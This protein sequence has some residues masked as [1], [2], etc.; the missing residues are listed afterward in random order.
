MESIVIKTFLH[1]FPHQPS[2]VAFD[3]IQRLLAIGT[4]NGSLRIL[5]R[6]GVDS[7]VRH[8]T[9]VAVLQIDFL[10]NEGALITA[11]SD[12][13]LHLWNFRQKR[14]EIVHS[15]KF[16]KERI[17][18]MF[19][20]VKSKWLYVGS[21]RG[22]IHVVNVESFALSGYVIN[23]NKA[24]DVINTK[25]PGPVVH[26]S[27]C[28]NDEN[29]LLIGYETGQVVLWNLRTKKAELRWQ[30]TEA[31]KSITWHYEGKQF[32][33]AH[34]DGTLT[35]W[36]LRPQ[37]KPSSVIAPHSKINK[38][39]KV[40]PACKPI[41]KVEW[42]TSKTGD[43]FIIFSGGT[44]YDTASRMPSLTVMHGKSTTVLEMEHNIVD[45]ITLCES[46]YVT[47]IQEPYAIVILLQYDL[48]LIDVQT[49]G[50]PSFENPYPMDI[51]E[52][53]VT[54]C[55]YFADCP[56]DIIPAFYSVGRATQ[57]RSG[58]SD[59]DWPI[60]GGEWSPTSCSYNEIIITGH[61]DGSIKFWDASAGTLQVLY[62]LKTAKIFEKPQSR[63]I[64]GN[65][66]DPFSIQLI[67][68]CP[69]S[70]KL[71]IAGASSY[72]ILFKFRKLES[73][74]EVSVL[75]IPTLSCTDVEPDCSPDFDFPPRGSITK[76][77]SESSEKKVIESTFPVKVKSAPQKKPPGF[78][79]HLVCLTAFAPTEPVFQMTSLALNSSYGLLAYGSENGVV[80]VDFVQ[81]CCLL[82]IASSD[83]YGNSD[84]FQRAPRSPKRNPASAE[85]SDGERCRS[86]SIDQCL[87]DNDDDELEDVSK[88][89]PTPTPMGADSSEI[90]STPIEET[91][92]E[93]ESVEPAQD[94]LTLLN[95]CAVA[96]TSVA[97]SIA[98]DDEQTSEMSKCENSKTTGNERRTSHSWKG[99]KFKKQLSKVDLKIKNTFSTADKSSKK[100]S[101]SVFHVNANAAATNQQQQ[102]VLDVP[103]EQSPEDES[104]VSD[105]GH[106]PEIREPS[107]S[108]SKLNEQ[109]DMPNRPTDLNLFE[110][111]DKPNRPERRRDRKRFSLEKQI[112][113]DT[114]LLSV[115][116]IKYQHVGKDTKKSKSS[117][118]PAFLGLIRRLN[119]LDSSFSRSRSSSMSSLENISSESIRCLAFS[120][121]Y[122]K[123]SDAMTVPTLWIGTSLGSVFYFT[124]NIPSAGE[125][126]SSQPIALSTVGSLP[127]LKSGILTISFLDCNGSLLRYSYEQWKDESKEKKTPTKNNPTSTTLSGS[128]ESVSCGGSAPCDKQFVVV[129]S[130]KQ[131]RVSAL[132]SHECV[133]KQQ[134]ADTDFVVKAEVIL[135]KD[136]VCLLCYISNSHIVAYGLPSLKPLI[137]VDFLPLS[138]LSFQTRK[139]GIVDP[140]LSIWG[141]QMFVNEDTNQIAK[142]F[143]FSNR[144]HGLYFSSPSEVQ[145]F[146]VSSDFCRD[147]SELVGEL[148][149]PRDMPEPPK[150]SLFKSLLGGGARSV[151]REELFGES[152]GKPIRSIAKHI[153]GPSGQLEQ[154]N[155]RVQH[156]TGEVGRA[157]RLMVER[158][159]KLGQL[160]ENTQRMMNDAEKFASSAHELMQKSKDKKWYQL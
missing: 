16:Q 1:G 53:P 41:Q 143:C 26:L 82:N 160:E 6:P 70:R 116:N 2:A 145:K 19:L 39:G 58:F 24:I 30:S 128:I 137:D 72:V 3:P 90:S 124:A 4:K 131:A 34:V 80:L 93:T 147:M 56:S 29:K 138:D 132:P 155:Q 37:D 140:M 76:N 21:E 113:R 123:K 10:L 67:S 61:A 89:T 81:K 22:N 25:H 149:L 12:D 154:L 108:E 11:T 55:S 35:T 158:G 106:L 62:K 47:D 15:L 120:D 134:L 114:R 104:L 17:T 32:M 63:S 115:P 48:V 141:Q 97:S 91:L 86:P 133:Y 92:V 144:G 139:Q 33:C 60:A 75:E 101:S 157:H 119:K 83:L 27:D 49:L 112:P 57:K 40:D 45:F 88:I 5:G 54:C 59:K 125:T 8:E 23:W 96:A 13:S 87:D 31:L 64:D 105:D 74:S 14:P 122:I 126:R 146:T 136:S 129:V 103:S 156:S 153:P 152:S 78:Q 111:D 94:A 135:L 66:V 77:E 151:D 79:A 18:C 71:A 38:D 99:F 28:P 20:P 109:C 46:P 150:Q 85:A 100:N 148:F 130:E 110:T 121:S 42:K 36:N 9:E 65:E 95:S 107:A 118:N 51:H 7:Q 43:A 102:P 159:D 73:T 84:P 68:L 117:N 69:E 142:T 127:R 44:T 52:S 98:G 50:F